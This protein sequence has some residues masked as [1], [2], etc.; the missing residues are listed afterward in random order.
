MKLY[1]LYGQFIYEVFQYFQGVSFIKWDIG[2][3]RDLRKQTLKKKIV[4]EADIGHGKRMWAPLYPF[5]ETLKM[6]GESR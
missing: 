6:G 5:I 3:D 1:V 2:G 4:N